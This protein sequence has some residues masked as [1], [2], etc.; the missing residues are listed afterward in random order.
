M[1]SLPVLHKTTCPRCGYPT[2]AQK[3]RT[4]CCGA[5]LS[6]TKPDIKIK[7]RRCRRKK[8]NLNLLGAETEGGV[9]DSSLAISA[10]QLA[11]FETGE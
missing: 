7:E 11:L 6:D 9:D 3:G 8:T 4:L 10:G 1:K 5:S 2:L